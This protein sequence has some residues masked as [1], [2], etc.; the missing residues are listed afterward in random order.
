MK[1]DEE[2]NSQA[3]DSFLRCRYALTPG[4]D[5]LS[6]REMVERGRCTIEV[7]TGEQVLSSYTASTPSRP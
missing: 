7:L 6:I 1:T 4:I 3:N 2:F 5:D